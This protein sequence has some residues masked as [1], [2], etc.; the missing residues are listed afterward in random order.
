MSDPLLA[1]LDQAVHQTDL[2]RHQRRVLLQEGVEAI[3]RV[4]RSILESASARAE[5]RAQRENR[6]TTEAG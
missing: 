5:T 2:A 1:R 6:A 4:R 3:R